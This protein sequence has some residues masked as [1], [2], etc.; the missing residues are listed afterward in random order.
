MVLPRSVQWLELAVAS[1]ACFQ[2]DKIGCH[3][4]AVAQVPPAFPISSVSS[5]LFAFALAAEVLPSTGQVHPIVSDCQAVVQAFSNIDRHADYRS[6]FA[7]MWISDNIA[8]IPAC[9]KA[10]AHLVQHEAQALGLE[11]YW[12]GNDKADYWAKTF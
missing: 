9:H 11:D 12:F 10:K 1:A 5:G 2:V 7:G 6:Q 8:R 3:R 4:L